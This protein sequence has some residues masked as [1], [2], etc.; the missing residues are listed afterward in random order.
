[1]DKI[2][3]TL[4]RDSLLVFFLMFFPPV[5]VCERECES[6]GCMYRIQ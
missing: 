3:S 1:M 5:C 2:F 4:A 6:A